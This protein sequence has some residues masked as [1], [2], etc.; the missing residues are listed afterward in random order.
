MTIYRIG[1]VTSLK[2]ARSGGSSAFIEKKK[3]S[4]KV[5]EPAGKWVLSSGSIASERQLA[6]P[7]N[8]Q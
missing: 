4:L 1:L 8:L 5:E 2:E 3:A 6:V 7:V